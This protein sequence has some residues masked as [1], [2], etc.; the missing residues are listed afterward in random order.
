MKLGLK[1]GINVREDV[2]L[3]EGLL[4]SLR[5]GYNTIRM[6]VRRIYG[7]LISSFK[8]FIFD[9]FSSIK[10]IKDVFSELI[11]KDVSVTV[12]FKI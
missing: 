4:Q 1:L 8:K 2:E 10:N 6:K 11:G 7:N 12:K 3:N 9:S 5:R